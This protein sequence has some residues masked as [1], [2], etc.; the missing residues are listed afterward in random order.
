VPVATRGVLSIMRVKTREGSIFAQ[1]LGSEVEIAME[2]VF[3]TECNCGCNRPN[4]L[5][6]TCL[7]ATVSITDPVVVD[8]LIATLQK[9]R[10]KLWGDPQS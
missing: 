4:R 5:D 7:G 8:H 9:G 1:S 2:F 3:R 6:V 10:G